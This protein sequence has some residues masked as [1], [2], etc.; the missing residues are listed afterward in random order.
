MKILS[1][2]AELSRAYGQ[3]DGQTGMTKLI[4]TFS[5]SSIA[6][7]NIVKLLSGALVELLAKLSTVN[8]SDEIGGYHSGIADDAGLLDYDAMS[9]SE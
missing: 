1:V 8:K 9:S 7:D 4:V 6:P 5:S 3:T 2:V